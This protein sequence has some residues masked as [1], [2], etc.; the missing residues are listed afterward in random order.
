MLPYFLIGDGFH[1]P[2][3]KLILISLCLF[4]F[5]QISNYV[6]I[7]NKNKIDQENFSRQVQA[8]GQDTAHIYFNWGG[9]N[10]AFIKPFDNSNLT[11][12]NILFLGTFGAHPLNKEKLKA[13][14]INNLMLEITTNNRILVVYKAYNQK[15]KK[16]VNFAIEDYKLYVKEHT[17]MKVEAKLVEQ[18]YEM[19]IWDFS[20]AAPADTL[21]P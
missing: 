6:T 4:A 5:F 8:V 9:I 12:K 10:S 13:F 2:K 21:A 18:K 17:G 20:P 16:E 1:R 7:S 11:A 14:G 19:S 15:F 3:K